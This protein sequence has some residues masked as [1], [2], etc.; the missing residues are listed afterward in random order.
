VLAI[1]VGLSLQLKE[2]YERLS[3]AIKSKGKIVIA[4]SGG[5]D[6][7]LLAKLAHLKLGNEAF[8]VL[9]DSETVPKFELSSAKELAEDIGISFDTIY[10]EQ[11]ADNRFVENDEKR[12]YYCRSS[13]ARSLIEFA[14]DHQV[15]TIAA[16]AQASDL[17][18]YR[19][20]IQA[21]NES[22]IWHPFIEFDFSKKDI[23]NL[24]KHLGLPT[25]NKPA[26][27]CLSSRI[28]YGQ[29]ITVSELQMVASAE[30][31]LRELGF[32]QY[33]A[34]THGTLLRIEVPSDEIELLLKSRDQ[35]LKKM[36]EIGYKFVTL[37]LE[38]FRSGS[39][40]LDL[41]NIPE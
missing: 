30:D 3:S 20:G 24:A 16:G 10:I 38:G 28:Q 27:A 31:Y 41:E 29:K 23:R 8:A 2:K 26:M 35:I 18:D 36:K 32:S 25:H 4:Y 15:D 22:G 37:D 33:R 21:F 14:K 34:R 6:S 12:C 9:V 11:L 1:T 13:M 40:N 5:V 7:A 19:P 17:D 39:M